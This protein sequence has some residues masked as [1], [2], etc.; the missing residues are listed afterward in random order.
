MTNR[1]QRRVQKH[2][3]PDNRYS[4]P[5]RETVCIS[6]CSND[7]VHADFAHSLSVAAIHGMGH[8]YS[9]GISNVRVTGDLGWGR[10]EQVRLAR[11]N[12]ATH[13]LFVDSDM[14]FPPEVIP[15]LLASYCPVIGATYSSRR[16]PRV[17]T[18]RDL[19]NP[20]GFPSLPHRERFA[21]AS[22]GMGCVMVDMSVF[23]GIAEPWFEFTDQCSED[24][25]F[26]RKVNAAGCSV[27]C[28]LPLSYQVRHVGQFAFGLEHVEHLGMPGET[29]TKIEVPV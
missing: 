2:G 17:L 6:Y 20:E 15:Y 27:I 10:N 16:S 24:I 23:E 28:D 26:F 22:L 4:A 11:A 25:Y 21:V 8:G 9:V 14:I 12:Q 18:H 29:L 19:D 5:S 1:K 7:M 13:I 3:L